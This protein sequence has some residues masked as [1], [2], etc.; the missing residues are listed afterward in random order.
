[1]ENLKTFISVFNLG[2]TFESP[3]NLKKKL[4]F[5]SKPLNFDFCG[6]R[7]DMDF[8][9]FLLKFVRI[10][11]LGITVVFPDTFNTNYMDKNSVILLLLSFHLNPYCNSKDFLGVH[12]PHIFRVCFLHRQPYSINHQ[13]Y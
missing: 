4:I 10:P 7:W 5:R 3:E 6:L 12:Y 11:M 1:M 13:N 9:I 2:Y 8:E